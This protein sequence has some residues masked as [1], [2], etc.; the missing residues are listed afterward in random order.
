MAVLRALWDHD[1]ASFQGR[2]YDFEGVSSQPRPVQARIPIWIASNPDPLALS[3]VAVDRALGRVA[4]T[5]DGWM[6]TV[7]DARAFG[8]QWRRIQ[9]LATEAGRDPAALE[10]SY[11]GMVHLHADAETAVANAKQYLDKYYTT[12]YSR[13]VLDSWVAYG[14]PERVAAKL[15]S[16]AEAGC[17]TLIL[18]FA[19]PDQTGQMRW[20]LRD[21][22]PLLADARVGTG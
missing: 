3:P 13:A 19:A 22:A 5:A 7:V 8:V 10:S 1:P 14:P 2:W 9:A 11:H 17:Q 4:R 6:T 20:F 16:F 12:D 21:V 18:R 15:R